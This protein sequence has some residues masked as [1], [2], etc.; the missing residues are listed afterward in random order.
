MYNPADEVP[1]GSPKV[2]IL[3]KNDPAKDQPPRPPP[4]PLWTLE[5]ELVE[6]ETREKDIFDAAS[7]AKIISWTTILSMLEEASYTR[8]SEAIS[9]IVKQTL[10]TLQSTPS[11]SSKDT[12][13]TELPFPGVLSAIMKYTLDGVSQANRLVLPLASSRENELR[14]GL[15]TLHLLLLCNSKLSTLPAMLMDSPLLHE[16]IVL[17]SSTDVYFETVP[18]LAV[19][20]LFNFTAFP[21]V[22]ILVIF[23]FFFYFL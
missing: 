13:E 16:L 20:Y 21:Q 9:S 23:F 22:L 8:R 19:K 14:V 4:P 11:A 2:I 6:I 1:L 7:K 5:S 12:V 17:L 18:L 15:V 3:P 10:N